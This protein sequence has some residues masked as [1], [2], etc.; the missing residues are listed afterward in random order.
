MMVQDGQPHF[1]NSAAVFWC[2]AR[3]IDHPIA[4]AFIRVRGVT[5]KDHDVI[6]KLL[7]VRLIEKQ[8]V[9]RQRFV[10]IAADERGV[11]K[12]E[13]LRVGKLGKLAGRDIV[14]TVFSGGSTKEFFTEWFRAEL[15]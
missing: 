8:Q 3:V 7:Y 15:Y 14:R 2:G 1:L 6:R 4:F 5:E 13:C 12:L 10:A 9:T 11:E